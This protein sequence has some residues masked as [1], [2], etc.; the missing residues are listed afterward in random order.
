MAGRDPELLPCWRKTGWAGMQTSLSEVDT[1]L[2]D[3]KNTNNK[4][5]FYYHFITFLLKLIYSFSS[6]NNHSHKSHPT[7][8]FSLISLRNNY[9]QLHAEK[10][11]HVLWLTNE[12]VTYTTSLNKVQIFR[13]SWV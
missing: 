9:A 4:F 12:Q 8:F 6:W 2:Q 7:N 13:D 3:P 1:E 11:T 10:V 5:Y